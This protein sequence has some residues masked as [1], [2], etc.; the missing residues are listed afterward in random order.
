[1]KGANFKGEN[2]T[3]ININSTLPFY[4]CV[5]TEGICSI[6]F[7]WQPGAFFCALSATVENRFSCTHNTSLSSNHSHMVSLSPRACPTCTQRRSHTHTFLSNF[8]TPLCSSVFSATCSSLYWLSATWILESQWLSLTPH[9]ITGS[10]SYLISSHKLILCSLPVE[11]WRL[12]QV[13]KWL[14]NKSLWS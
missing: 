8:N 12:G 11:K 7:P 2:V 9:I 3:N 10:H 13:N 4:L 14:V 5:L 6:T 1:M